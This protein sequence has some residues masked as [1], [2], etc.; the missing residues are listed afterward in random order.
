MP[1]PVF[2]VLGDAYYWLFYHMPSGS[3]IH[4]F[5]FE[6]YLELDFW[7]SLSSERLGNIM[8]FLPF[9]ILY[10]LFD[11]K[12]SWKRT[13]LAGIATSVIIELLQPIF[14]RIFDI[15]DIV[16]NS[17]SV[18]ISTSIFFAIRRAVSH[19]TNPIPK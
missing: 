14:G 17:I 9:G 7:S 1:D 15:N 5:T 18:L 4:W 10:P 12:T 6:Y 13:L 11:K 8:M 2:Y 3:G 16:L 19:R